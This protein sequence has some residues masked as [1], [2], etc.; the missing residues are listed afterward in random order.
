MISNE[1]D[2]RV[3]TERRFI[4]FMILTVRGLKLDYLRK[5]RKINEKEIYYDY[6]N[7]KKF[8]GFENEIRSPCCDDYIDELLNKLTPK[9]RQVIK[10]TILHD[11][12]EE[13]TAKILYTS[14]QMVNKTKH[15][16]LNKLK[17]FI[18]E[19]GVYPV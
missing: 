13:S 3:I 5:Q 2:L 9:E 14:Q 1:E 6:N 17:H 12:T 7:T 16:A 15:Q 11:K 10:L 4:K 19:D 18:Q 8:Y